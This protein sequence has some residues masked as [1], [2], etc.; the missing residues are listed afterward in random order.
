MNTGVLPVEYI[1][2]IGDHDMT[3]A[4]SLSDNCYDRALFSRRLEKYWVTFNSVTNSGIEK[5]RGKAGGLAQDPSI[6]SWGS[7]FRDPSDR[8][9]WG[10][11]S[12]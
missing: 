4:F 11:H 3:D 12:A 7:I 8:L 1:Q 9:V 6:N 5:R 2:V 10:L